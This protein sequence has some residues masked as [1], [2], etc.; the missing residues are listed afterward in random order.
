MEFQV[1]NRFIKYAIKSIQYEN[2]WQGNYLT[3]LFLHVLPRKNTLWQ[4]NSFWWMFCQ[5]CTQSPQGKDCSSF[6]R[7][8]IWQHSKV[9]E[10]SN[11]IKQNWCYYLSR[12]FS[13]IGDTVS[14]LKTFRVISNEVTIS[15]VILCWW[16]ISCLQ[17]YS[18]Q[19]FNIYFHA[20]KMVFQIFVPKVH[21][22]AFQENNSLWAVEFPLTNLQVYC[23]SWFWH[24][25]S[26]ISYRGM[27]TIYY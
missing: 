5:I 27:R 9:A 2:Q 17:M 18:G 16:H 22:S 21:R 20:L 8:I 12:N 24:F 1:W 25:N 6:S 11:W 13:G 14:H 10:A 4:I 15:A 3:A 19:C 26:K 23:R 7:G